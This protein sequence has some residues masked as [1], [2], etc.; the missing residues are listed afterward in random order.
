MRI[1]CLLKPVIDVD[2]LRYDRDRNTLLREQARLML[3]PEDATAAATA[4][5]IKRAVPATYI[6]AVSMAP[7]AA[8]PHLED[9]VRRGFDQAAL[10]CDPRYAGSDTWATSRVLARY[11]RTREYDSI[12]CGTHTLDGGTGQVPAQIAELLGLPVMVGITTLVELDPRKGQAVVE[13]DGETAL[14][15]FSVALPAVLGF[16]YR[17][18]RKLPYLRPADLQR[19]VSDQVMVL[20]NTELGMDEAELGLRGSLTQVR[21]IAVEAREAKAP[22]RLRVDREGLDQVCRWLEQRGFLQP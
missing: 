7:R 17:P 11:L 3:N 15:R 18:E 5:E 21:H 10:L 2:Q 1:L 20:G 19:D 9:L 4:L 6:E 12:F 8:R 13:V 16:Q 14:L 22:L